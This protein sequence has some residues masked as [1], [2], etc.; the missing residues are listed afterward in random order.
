MDPTLRLKV[1][2]SSVCRNDD[3]CYD[4]DSSNPNVMR[5]RSL[6]A[7]VVAVSSLF[8]LP[9]AALATPLNLRDVPAGDPDRVAIEFLNRH[10]VVY[11]SI[12]GMFHP[13]ANI[14]RG[15]ILKI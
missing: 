3:D 5:T 1:A 13:D 9:A 15:E 12:D 4:G 8:A 14:T 6:A 10:E 7:L 11:G 2:Q